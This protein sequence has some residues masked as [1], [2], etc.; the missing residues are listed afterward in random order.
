[1]KRLFSIILC[2]TIALS[3]FFSIP[4]NA[5]YDASMKELQ[6]HSDCLL[7][8]SADNDEIIF[9]KN[10]RKQTSPASLTKIV[11][12]IVVIENCKN[13]NAVTTVTEECIR[14]LDGTGSSMG[15][16]KAGEQL[17][18]YD[19]LCYLMIQ[20]ANDA[21]T[22]LANYVTGSNRAA[23]I[24]KMNEVV[25]RLGC[26]NTNFVN[27]HGL[28]HD[29]QYTTA[30][31]M[32]KILKHAM[33][34]SAFSEI[35]GKLSYTVPANNLKDERH[36]SNT[37]YLLNKNYE[38]YYCKY[39][40][41]GKTGT[42]SKAGHCLVTYAS[43]DGYNYIAIALKSTMKDFDNDGWDE[44]GA[45][46]D[47]KEML[48]WAFKNIELV[49]ICDTGKIAGEVKVNYAKSTDFVSLIPA[50]TVYSLVPLGTNKGSVLVEPI[51]ESIPESVDAPIK[52]GDFICKGRVLYAGEVL[53]EIDLVASN[54]VKRSFFS[55]IGTK[56][57]NLVTNPIFI[58]ISILVIISVAV[59]LI[60]RNK[61]RK[62]HA[63][64]GRDYKI[65][66]Y[67]DFTR[68]K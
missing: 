6:L 49:P 3:T 52:K 22:T 33:S 42:T 2:L 31:D 13:L 55:L 39:V 41:S 43:K 12:A 62:S 54:D 53:R 63:V 10:K 30:E 5:A 23:F 60:I 27:P 24:A 7:L 8:I 4:S 38:D 67:K 45:F 64:A 1:M 32:A 25:S 47:C 46:L 19:L 51:P 61:K 14:E 29:D 59:A 58:I 20:S 36:L 65:L 17:R 26:K 21:A 34:L 35:T 15:N 66:N 18:I 16:L 11:T 44:N 37:C 68:M 50:E 57:K 9:E 48:E 56:A 40:K 28:D